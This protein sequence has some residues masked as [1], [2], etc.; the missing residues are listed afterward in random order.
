MG[1]I[2]LSQGFNSI[3][4]TVVLLYFI[5]KRVK[6]FKSVCCSCDMTT[7]LTPR[8]NQ[9]ENEN[10]NENQNESN[11]PNQIQINEFFESALNSVIEN[12]I[13]DINNNN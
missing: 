7:G 8:N 3:G 4:L 10:Q 9:N 13:N 12:K 1:L 11:Q 6:K 2:A 5:S